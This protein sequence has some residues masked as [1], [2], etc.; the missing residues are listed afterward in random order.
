MENVIP[1]TELGSNLPRAS[2]I[3]TNFLIL[4]RKFQ[5]GVPYPNI[6]SL[7]SIYA[8]E[9]EVGLM[10]VRSTLDWL[11]WKYERHRSSTIGTE[12][13]QNRQI[14]DPNFVRILT[15]Q[16][17]THNPNQIKICS[18][19]WKQT[20][21]RRWLWAWRQIVALREISMQRFRTVEEET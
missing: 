9:L 4:H 7:S 12:L 15:R 2:I 5:L 18:G 11:I 17:G 10:V 13:D 6:G 19:L 20:F 8:T 21:T 3:S 16:R 1:M 14:A